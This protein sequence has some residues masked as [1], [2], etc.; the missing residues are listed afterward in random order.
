MQ[1][2]RQRAPGMTFQAGSGWESI[3][4]APLVTH[5]TSR[6]PGDS[7]SKAFLCPVSEARAGPGV[8]QGPG[9]VCCMR[10]MEGG[11]EG[12]KG[13]RET[14]RE[15]MKDRWTGGWQMRDGWMEGWKK[16][17]WTSH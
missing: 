15:E 3:S 5:Q 2:G 12:R 16:G 10:R 8:E 11:R 9:N 17:G 6:V 13:G 7:L 1:W 14:G 4:R